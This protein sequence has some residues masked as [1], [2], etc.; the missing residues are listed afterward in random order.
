MSTIYVLSK[1]GKPLMPNFVHKETAWQEKLAKKKTGLN[2]RYG[3]LSVLN[4]IIPA[5][6]KEL[7]SLFPKHFL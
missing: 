3:A 7:S 1:D 4:Q 2:K 5:L 6:T